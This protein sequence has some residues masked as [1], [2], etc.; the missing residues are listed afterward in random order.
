MIHAALVTE[1]EGVRII[2]GSVIARRH[3]TKGMKAYFAVLMHPEVATN[4]KGTGMKERSDSVGT[5]TREAL[6]AKFGVSADLID[7]ACKL[8]ERF[9]HSKSLRE[10]HEKLIWAGF[11]LGGIIAGLAGAASTKDQAI[12]ANNLT[13]GL[14][15]RLTQF[16]GSIVQTWTKIG[17]DEE[18][19][20]FVGESIGTFLSKLPP[21]LRAIARERLADDPEA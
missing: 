7:Q 16:G 6:A 20:Q 3:W 15:R 21:E 14:F 11:G 18:Q 10:A 2:E 12:Q 19:R 9:E 13:A 8:Y 5:L 1:E 17:A 4:T